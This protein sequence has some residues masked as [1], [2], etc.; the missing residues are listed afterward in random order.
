LHL[1]RA[2]AKLLD[3]KRP[4]ASTQAIGQAKAA[5]DAHR[6]DCETCRVI[7]MIA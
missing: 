6:A 1:Y 7:G 3:Q 5:F 4:K 2:W